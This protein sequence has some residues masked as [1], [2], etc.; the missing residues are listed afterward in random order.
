MAYIPDAVRRRLPFESL[1]RYTRVRPDIVDLQWN[2]TRLSS[3][4]LNDSIKCHG[5]L[6]GTCE[7]LEHLSVRLDRQIFDLEIISPTLLDMVDGLK[8]PPS[9]TAGAPSVTR[10]LQEVADL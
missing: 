5:N 1:L 8:L 6:A 4:K 9:S 2:G 7:L 3:T 10:L